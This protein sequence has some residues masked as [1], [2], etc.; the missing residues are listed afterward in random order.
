[1]HIPTTPEEWLGMLLLIGLLLT[2][3]LWTWVKNRGFKKTQTEFKE[4]KLKVDNHLSTQIED[5]QK[6]FNAH[7]N[8]LAE[9]R[10]GVTNELIGINKR[11]DR[12]EKSENGEK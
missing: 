3:T 8:D 9:W 10:G 1:M 6:C 11:I 7:C 5:L 12:L 4:T 2:L